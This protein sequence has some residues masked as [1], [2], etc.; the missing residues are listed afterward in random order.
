[1]ISR[2][3]ENKLAKLTKDQGV[4]GSYASGSQKEALI[5][6]E[7]IKLG[8]IAIAYAIGEHA[9]ATRNPEWMKP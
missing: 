7:Q 9:E 6:G 3:L 5:Q 2:D 4:A 8:L 1:M